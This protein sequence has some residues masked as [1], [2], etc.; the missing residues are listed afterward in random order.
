MINGGNA[1]DAAISTT[2]CVSVV[3]L[4]VGGLG[5]GG[6]LTFY[7]KTDSAV[8]VIDAQVVAPSYATANMFEGNLDAAVKGEALLI[9]LLNYLKSLTLFV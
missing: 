5:G 1:I 6:F 2:F 3:N 7:N 8:T 4:H 9:K